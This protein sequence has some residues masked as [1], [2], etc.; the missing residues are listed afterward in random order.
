[1]MEPD[2]DLQ[3]GRL[4]RLS[5]RVQRLV[6]P[7]A[8]LMTGPG[9]NSYVLGE[10]AVLDPGPADPAHLKKLRVAAPGLHFVFVTHTHRDHSCG[11]RALAAAAGA[12]IVGLPPPSDGL[13]D[14]SC[15]P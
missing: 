4:V 6:A 13:Q 2:D 8:S 10:V 3:P 1:V 7:N 15:T 11:A 5:P 9:T 14:L 12:A